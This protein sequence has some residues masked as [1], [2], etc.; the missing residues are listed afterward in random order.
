MIIRAL[1]EG[2]KIQGPLQKDHNPVLELRV[3]L[4]MDED[5]DQLGEEAGELHSAR[6]GDGCA[7]PNGGQPASIVVM[8]GRKRP[9]L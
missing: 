4:Q 1:A 6:V 7:A 2:E 5:P 8:E 9:A 3:A